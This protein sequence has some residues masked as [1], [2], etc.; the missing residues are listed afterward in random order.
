M[1]RFWVPQ[2]RS[3]NSIWGINK[4]GLVALA[5][6]ESSMGLQEAQAKTTGQLRL[7]IREH[8]DQIRESV[9]N[10]PLAVKPIGLNGMR[11]AQL[12]EECERRSLGVYRPTGKHMCR[13]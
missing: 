13:E 9:D 12:V 8:R 6:N 11:V 2:V 4:A 5:I 3:Q 10:D 7:T 1:P